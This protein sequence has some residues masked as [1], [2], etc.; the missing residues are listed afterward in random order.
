MY[1]TG[2]GSSVAAVWNAFG[3]SVSGSLPLAVTSSDR[4]FVIDGRQRIRFVA[5]FANDSGTAS[6]KSSFAVLLT[7]EV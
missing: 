6:T 5:D 2:S 1:L 3:V 4:A 7:D